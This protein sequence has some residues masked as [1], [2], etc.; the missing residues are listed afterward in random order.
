[1]IKVQIPEV[2]K[3]LIDIIMSKGVINQADA[4]TL[5]DDYVE[6]EIQGKKSHGLASFIA[7]VP[8][9]SDKRS[10]MEI[11]KESDSALYIDAHGGFGSIEGRKAAALLIK[12]AKNQGVAAGFIRNIKSWL[13]PATVAQ[14]VAEHDMVSFVTNTGGSAMVAPPGGKDPVIGT[15]PIGIGIPSQQKPVIVDM[16]TSKRAWGEVRLA[17]KLGHDLPE[18]SYYDKNGNVA[19]NPDD[20]YSA[21]PMG[22]YKGFSLGLLIEIMGGSFV[23]MPMGKGD[24]GESAYER[25]RGATILVFDPNFTVGVP[26]FKAANHD[27]LGKIHNSSTLPDSQAVTIPG[28]RAS[29]AK[30]INTRNGYLEI[31]DALWEEIKA[32]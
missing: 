15:N 5:A 9:L 30:A 3:T 19:V 32:L 23:A 28:D 1:M 6:G 8:T 7:V 24:P 11:I 26:G 4:E 14:Y 18:N 16:A 13:R 12:K 29:K 22:D 21:F 20:A 10:G 17:K 2:R 27:F 31:D 25:T